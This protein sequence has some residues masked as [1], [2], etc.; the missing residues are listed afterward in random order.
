MSQVL[1]TDRLIRNLK[2]EDGDRID[3]SDSMIANDGSLP[4]SLIL[5]VS[6]TGRKT[7]Q[8]V[9]RIGW[10]ESN[11]KLKRLSLG[12]YPALPLTKAREIARNNLQ[13]AASGIDPAQ[14]KQSELTVVVA[15]AEYIERHAKPNQR[16]WKETQRILNAELI[17]KHRGSK[18]SEVTTTHIRDIINTIE[19]RGASIQA[20][21]TLQTIKAFW[22]WLIDRGYSEISPA[23]PLRPPTKERS[24]DRVLED[25][26]VQLFWN[27]CKSMGY[28]FGSVFQLLL[29]TAQRRQEVSSIRWSELDLD[30]CVWKIPA[31]KTKPN[32]EHIVPL[33]A[34]AISIISKT[35]RF[36]HDLLFSNTGTTAVS[37]FSRAKRKLDGLMQDK[38]Q[39]V[40]I[41]PWRLHDLRRTAT[42]GMARLG[43]GQVTIEK[44]LNHSSGKLSGVAAVYNRYGYQKEKSEALNDWADY[45]MDLVKEL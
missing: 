24:R 18:L 39:G 33:S 5:R 31:S 19:N 22:R 32:R 34:P 21:R 28:P 14:K 23:D 45:V 41:M 35:P 27:A 42:S 37:G 25:T 13:E 30:S 1:F 12:L 11:R 4:G 36:S 6:Q 40:T 20:N 16:R 10:G 29:L 38:T 44:V 8:V 15:A 43:S 3:Y 17:P 7:W 26:E 2:A 9:Y